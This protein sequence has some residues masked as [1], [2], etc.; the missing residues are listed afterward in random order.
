MRLVLVPLKQELKSLISVLNG[1]EENSD[2]YKYKDLQF[3]VGGLGK[4]KFSLNTYK[5]SLKYQPERVY[6]V[7]SCGSLKELEPLEVVF[8]HKVIEHDFRSSFM[9]PPEYINNSSEFTDLKRVSCASGD[10]DIVTDEAK[11]G[12]L[13]KVNADI[14][15]WESAGFFSAFD[16]LEVPYA[17]IRVITDCANES[18]GE[19]F[20]K[21][22][23]L[24]MQKIG[25]LFK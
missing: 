12:L 9:E 2:G 21:N 8:V 20:K 25:M 11:K 10:V 5:Y 6:A 18:V 23:S 22:L 24:G 4:L 19:D 3:V 14:V 16:Y 7:G 1:V 15:T 13:S 17:E